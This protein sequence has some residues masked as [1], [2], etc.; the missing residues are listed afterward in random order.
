[1]FRI[2]AIETLKPD[3]DLQN[4]LQ[5]AQV[6]S[7]NDDAAAV[8]V[9]RYQSIMR[10]LKAEQIYYLT[11][12]YEVENGHVLK[13][14]ETEI[15]PESFFSWEKAVVEPTITISTI[16][17]Q[18]G[19]G[20]STLMMLLL[21]LMNNVSY[22]LRDE[23]DGSLRRYL[24]FVDD[25]F[26]R[27][28]IEV[29]NKEEFLIVEQK[30]KDLFVT[31]QKGLNDIAAQPLLLQDAFADGSIGLKDF[32]YTIVVD[33]ASYSYNIYDYIPEWKDRDE[34]AEDLILFDEKDR[35]WFSP[36]FHKN[37][38][39]QTPI[40]INPYR[41][42]GNIDFNNERR[43]FVE[44]LNHLVL[45][46]KFEKFEMADDLVPRYY[47]FDITLNY[48]PTGRN[49][50][51]SFAVKNVLD[52]ANVSLGTLQEIM[53]QWKSVYGFNI[54]QDWKNNPDVRRTL[55]YIAYKTLKI[56]LTYA[57][58]KV[59][60]AILQNGDV[61]ITEFVKE[62]FEDKSH[63]TLK[64]RRAFAFLLF[65]HYSTSRKG[66][67]VEKK[68]IDID[69]FN[70]K[71]N[72]ILADINSYLKSYRPEIIYTGN[73][74]WTR[75]DLWPAGSF[76][77]NVIFSPRG[78]HKLTD[79]IPYSMLSSGIKQMMNVNTII[80]YH[81]YNIQSVWNNERTGIK[82]RNVCLL[83]D[84]VELYYHPE[85]QMQLV[86]NLI[87]IIRNL[88]ISKYIKGVQVVLLTHSPFVFSDI[89]L[90]NALAL[91]YGK[92]KEIADKATF[93]ANIYDILKNGFFLHK[94]MGAFA[95]AKIKP[96]IANLQ[97]KR[98]LSIDKLNEYEQL[99]QTIGDPILRMHIKQLL[100]MKK[101]EAN[102]D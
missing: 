83:F 12:G 19:Q 14:N 48:S 91:E 88:G 11:K 51:S 52:E 85:Y 84:E 18:N 80:L 24:Y 67:P 31:R 39:Y 27:L 34:A 20:K 25:V 2:I 71:I 59:Y 21:R 86:K 16:V 8:R 37:D 44:R 1:M 6:A 49:L 36:L 98:K 94:Y 43:L 42:N 99:I 29:T 26:A 54:E 13:K 79:E 61:G 35:C 101:D 72:L 77:V 17:G 22:M 81:L 53:N 96:M 82:Y 97:Q 23:M 45:N 47:V 78:E 93:A 33:Y 60:A 89:P 69:E 64:L 28:Y 58:Y 100:E 41:D 38:G 87:V 32:F 46:N 57:R 90:N 15:L 9:A 74:Q 4:N 75:E 70:N 7:L 66:D 68:R 95:L 73:V 102:K 30:G 10:I 92:P 50:Y 65:R 5:I 76:D 63:I 3:T 55:N 40:V 62:L 56:H